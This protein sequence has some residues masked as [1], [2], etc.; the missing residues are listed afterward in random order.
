[1]NMIVFTYVAIAII[2]L[3]A[4]LVYFNIADHF[5]IIDK[6]NQR[7]SHTKIVL[8]GGGIIFLIGAWVWAIWQWIGMPDQVGHD[9][10]PWFLAAVTLAAGV[11]FIDDIHSLPDSVRLVV[12]FVAMGLMFYQ[13]DMIHVELWWAVI[14]ALI[15]CVGATNIYNFMDGINGIT[16][17]YSLA[18]LVPLLALNEMSGGPSASSGTAGQFIETSFIVVTILSVLV[19]SYFN[20]RPKNKA[21]CFAGDVGSVGIAFILLFMIGSLIMKTGDITW[22]IFLIVYGV[23]GCCTIVHRIMLHEHLGEAHRKHAYQIMANELGMS[24]VVVSLIYMAIQ[25]LISLGMVYL[26]PNTVVAHWIY[27]VVVGVV[28]V[29]AY[30]L[31]MKKYYHLHEEYLKSL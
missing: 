27:L 25:L 23:D 18:V 20:F 4:E 17:G 22:L 26:I 9:G 28:L 2:L 12:Q 6:P 1:M 30:V 5:N 8:R 14:L 24:H 15:V 16:A 13:L 7:S 19:F 11:S 21:K 3:I 31:F 10:Y 29:A